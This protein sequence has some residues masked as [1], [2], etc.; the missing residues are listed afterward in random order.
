[1]VPGP[2][3]TVFEI[4]AAIR[5]LYPSSLKIIKSTRLDK[6]LIDGLLSV[7]GLL[8][9]SSWHHGA[10]PDWSLSIGEKSPY[11]SLAGQRALWP[12]CDS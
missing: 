7:S 6:K 3:T 12:D 2:N 1:M 10:H 11:H 9:V 8:F 5:L 4:R